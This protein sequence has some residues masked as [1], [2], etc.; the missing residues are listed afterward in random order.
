MK[1]LKQ[2]LLLS[3]VSLCI[4]SNFYVKLTSLYQI[5][6]AFYTQ[7]QTEQGFFPGDYG[8]PMF[9]LPGLVI[10]CY[11]TNVDLGSARRKAMLQYLLNHQQRDGGWGTHIEG[12][13]TMFGTTLNYTAARLLGLGEDSKEAVLARE[14]LKDRRGAL[15]GKH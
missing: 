4:A 14:F 11:V 6:S 15:A 9:L 12:Q 13:S 10:A 5:G 2:Q 1:V 8:G 3:S 7:L